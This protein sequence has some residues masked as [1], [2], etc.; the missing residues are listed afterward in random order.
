MDDFAGTILAARIKAGLTQS[1]VAAA[2]G[3]TASYL[4]FIENRKRP[5]PSDEV[6]T[7][8]ARVLKVPDRRLVE[9]AHYE[10]APA[11]LRR[12]LQSLDASLRRER[13][14]RLNFLRSLFGPLFGEA[15]TWFESTVDSII[16]SPARRRYLREIYRALGR[17]GI[18]H[19]DRLAR[20]LE[21]LP[22]KE[23]REFLAALP[24]A[25]GRRGGASAAPAERD[26]PPDPGR[27]AGGPYVLVAPV[28]MVEANVEQGDRLVVD[29]STTP[30]N[31][32]LVVVR[33]AGGWF[34][35]RVER[36]GSGWRVHGRGE[37]EAPMDDPSWKERWRRAGAGVVVEI[38]RRLRPNR[39]E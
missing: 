22:A 30:E 24:A 20:F 7:R 25:A 9:L 4:S 34:L 36:T 3:L 28:A 35:A 11:P 39:A 38:R 21:S 27:P 16:P 33:E 32:D 2:A 37:A 10:R 31:G 8:L 18:D 19:A 6:V 12:R 17:K 23:R 15:G 13:R 26:A 5:P 14:S 29:P 1:Q